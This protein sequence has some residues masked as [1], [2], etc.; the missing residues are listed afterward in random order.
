MLQ[1]TPCLSGVMLRSSGV[2]WDLRAV[3]PSQAYSLEYTSS[4]T[5]LVACIRVCCSVLLVY[6]YLFLV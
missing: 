6:M 4:A 1:E 5:A 2:S 3:M